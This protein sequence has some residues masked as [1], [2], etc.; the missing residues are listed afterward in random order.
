MDWLNEW[1]VSELKGGPRHEKYAAVA[2]PARAWKKNPKQTK[3]IVHEGGKICVVLRVY[4]KTQPITNTLKYTSPWQHF[5]AHDF[6]LWHSR[7]K[8]LEIFFTWILYRFMNAG[9]TVQRADGPNRPNPKAAHRALL[10]GL[11]SSL[12][13]V[14]FSAFLIRFLKYLLFPVTIITHAH[15][16]VMQKPLWTSFLILKKL[17][18]LNHFSTLMEIWSRIRTQFFPRSWRS[19]S[20]A[21]DRQYCVWGEPSIHPH[22]PRFVFRVPFLN[23]KYRRTPTTLSTQNSFFSVV[24]ELR[25]FSVRWSRFRNAWRVGSVKRISACQYSCAVESPSATRWCQRQNQYVVT[26]GTARIVGRSTM[27]NIAW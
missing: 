23:A 8:S 13:F 19:L 9:S 17:S 22:T 26:R 11:Q 4:K 5:L 1:K 14:E 10:G 15:F 27:F 6:N 25:W 20:L 2:S 24:C 16:W 3:I 21:T 7:E 12:W 18:W